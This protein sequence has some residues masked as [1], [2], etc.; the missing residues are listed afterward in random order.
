MSA[1]LLLIVCICHLLAG[2]FEADKGNMA[3]AIMLW[4]FAIGDGAML[5]MT[6]QK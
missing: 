1:A 5:Y 2:V 3:M 4:A 6:M